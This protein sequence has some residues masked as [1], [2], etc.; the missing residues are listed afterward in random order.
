MPEVYAWMPMPPIKKG[1]LRQRVLLYDVPESTTDGYA[2]PS[3]AG[4]PI[5][6]ADPDHAFAADVQP[7][8]GD[9]QMTVRQQFPTATHTVR[10]GWLGSTIPASADNPNALILPSMYLVDLD[11]DSILNVLF[12]EDVD[13]R[14]RLWKLTCMAH[15]GATS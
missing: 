6:S 4:D 3:L 14:H 12:A 10:L 11:D 1:E 8:K 2:Q 7:L 15:V 5:P 13:K 9:E